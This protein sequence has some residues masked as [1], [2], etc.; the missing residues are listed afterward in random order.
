MTV[1][2]D[3]PRTTRVP[4]IDARTKPLPRFVPVIFAN[5]VDDDLPGIE[6]ALRD[7]AVQLDGVICEPGDPVVVSNCTSRLR[8]DHVHFMSGG[9]LVFCADNGLGQAPL[10]LHMAATRLV[11]FEHVV[12][13]IGKAP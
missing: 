7:E 11:M 9:N 4:S 3:K 6:A 1:I 12:F 2:T 13:I 10:V 5:G 8:V